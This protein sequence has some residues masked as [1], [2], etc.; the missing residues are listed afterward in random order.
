MLRIDV[1]QRQHCEVVGQEEAPPTMELLPTT[2][3]IAA[4][5]KAAANE[6]AV[7][8]FCLARGIAFLV[9]VPVLLRVPRMAAVWRLHQAESPASTAPRQLAKLCVLHVQ[10]AKDDDRLGATARR[11]Q[12]TSQML[13]ALLCGRRPV[14]E[15]Q[16]NECNL[17]TAHTC[18]GTKA[19]HASERTQLLRAE[20][21]PN[22]QL[23]AASVQAMARPGTEEAV[24][25]RESLATSLPVALLQREDVGARAEHLGVDCVQV[26]PLRPRTVIRRRL[27]RLP[28]LELAAHVPR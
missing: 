16:C 24:V 7:E 28:R 15:V 4:A 18:D 13:L 9:R 8:A 1:E 19:R 22:V 12:R 10:V 26:V 20:P 21:L 25:C 23:H 3:E 11:L 2:G 27:R 17:H 5:V 6:H 14:G